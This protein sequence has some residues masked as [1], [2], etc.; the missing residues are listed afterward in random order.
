[1]MIKKLMILV[2]MTGVAFLSCGEDAGNNESKDKTSDS[3]AEAARPENKAVSP[4]KIQGAFGYNLGDAFPGNIPRIIQPNHHQ[5]Y[6]FDIEKPFR[7]FRRAVVLLTP[8]SQHIYEIQSEA[9]F[10]TR[11]ECML[12]FQLL[13]H[14]LKK[15]YEIKPEINYLS[16]RDTAIFNEMK[17]SPDG[18]CYAAAIGILAAKHD[19][20]YLLQITYS[21]INMMIRA[22]EQDEIIRNYYQNKLLSNDD[23]KVL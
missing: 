8:I 14:A 12:E 21:D 6:F 17:S 9:Q 18:K 5:I 13:I 4:L 11:E 20:K 3:A 15:K 16:D 2:C 22:R 23:T 7:K 10:E 1:M 19:G